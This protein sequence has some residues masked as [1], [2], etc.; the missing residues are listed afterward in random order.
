MYKIVYVLLVSLVLVQPVK[1]AVHVYAPDV[2][3]EAHSSKLHH[4]F[5]LQGYGS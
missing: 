1:K 5:Q 2:K 3:V 4:D